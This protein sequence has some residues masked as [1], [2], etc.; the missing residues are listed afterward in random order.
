MYKRQ[1]V[2][3][4]ELND[5]TPRILTLSGD[6]WTATFDNLPKYDEKGNLYLYYALELTKNADGMYTPVADNGSITYDDDSYHVD[7]DHTADDESPTD[8]QST[9]ITNTPSTSLTG[10]K[11]WKDNSNA[12]GTR[13]DDLTLKLHRSINGTEWT[14]VSN[15]AEEGITFAWTDKDETADNKWVY[16]F[17]NLPMYDPAGNKYTYKVEEVVPEGYKADTASGEVNGAQGPDFTN[18][19]TGTCLLYTS[20][21]V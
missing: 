1:P 5:N 19:L 15:L 20:R 6:S 14:E 16:T 2:P 7:Y 17:A 9:T 4:D 13:P 8:P 12:Y 11:T 3:K 10:T 18:T 21:C